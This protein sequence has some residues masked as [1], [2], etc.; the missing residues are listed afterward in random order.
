MVLTTADN[1]TF[2][3]QVVGHEVLW[4][5]E[6]IEIIPSTLTPT[7]TPGSQPSIV[8]SQ[9]SVAGSCPQDDPDGSGDDA[10]GD[11]EDKGKGQGDGDGHVQDKE[12]AQDEDDGGD[13]VKA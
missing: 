2:L 8:G 6:D 1:V 10:E 3:G 7:P 11:G 5:K 12:K 9:R 13:K 4:N